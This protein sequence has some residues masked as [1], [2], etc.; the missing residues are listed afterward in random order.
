MF[1]HE[2]QIQIARIF[3]SDFKGI[4]LKKA[5]DV[6]LVFLNMIFFKAIKISIMIFISDP[7]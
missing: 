6:L 4:F 2:F 7:I 1:K 3:L 5:A